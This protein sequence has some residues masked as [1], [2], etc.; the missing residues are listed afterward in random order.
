MVHYSRVGKLL[1][2]P[3]KL[4][5]PIL[6]WTMGMRNGLTSDRGDTSIP[7]GIPAPAHL[8]GSPPLAPFGVGDPTL[9]YW[10]GHTVHTAYYVR[11]VARKTW[12]EMRAGCK[13]RAS[14]G[15]AR[16]ERA[17]R[18]VLRRKPRSRK[19]QADVRQ[20][21]AGDNPSGH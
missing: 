15:L 16:A 4:E 5:Q 19:R 14:R 7:K 3:A 1:P 11:I 6:R 12:V 9:P 2:V 10:Q 17:G 8:A 13:W 21:H 20:S 18:A